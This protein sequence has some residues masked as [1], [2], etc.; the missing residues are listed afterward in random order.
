MI[1]QLG[2]RLKQLRE[3]HD[4]P[5]S[6][7]ADEIG[8]STNSV[9]QAEKGTTRTNI[10]FM[11]NICKFYGISMDL[12]VFGSDADFQQHIDKTEGMDEELSQSLERIGYGRANTRWHKRVDA[13]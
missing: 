3:A 9:W 13:G 11:A 12:L 2:K 8:F 4:L 7:V 6:Y 1:E 10:E 5:G